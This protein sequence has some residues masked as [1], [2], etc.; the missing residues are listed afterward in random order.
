[1]G[2]RW[3][4]LRIASGSTGYLHVLQVMVRVRRMP[5]VEAGRVARLPTEVNSTRWSARRPVAALPPPPPSSP[6]RS[7]TSNALATRWRSSSSRPSPR[8][9]ARPPCLPVGARSPRSTPGAR[10]RSTSPASRRSSPIWL[11][12]LPTDLVLELAGQHRAD[13]EVIMR[14]PALACCPRIASLATGRSKVP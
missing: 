2:L 9:E 11:E 13:C 6:S 1:M 4:E 7:S 12:P 10:L 8:C 14:S 5:R 3:R